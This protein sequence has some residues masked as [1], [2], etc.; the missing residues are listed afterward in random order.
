MRLVSPIALGIKPSGY[1]FALKRGE[2]FM[3]RHSIQDAMPNKRTKGLVA[4]D[5]LPGQ[6]ITV[7]HAGQIE[8]RKKS[9][10]LTANKFSEMG[11]ERRKVNAKNSYFC[12]ICNREEPFKTSYGA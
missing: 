11:I 6:Y 2:I 10:Q 9:P 7:Y 12:K 8:S 1:F 5:F 3:R 4:S